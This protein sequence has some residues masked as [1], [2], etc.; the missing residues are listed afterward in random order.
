MSHSYKDLFV[1][2]KSKALAVQIYAVTKQFPR[3][4]RFGLVSQMRRAAV[5]VASSIAEGQGRASK[6]EF[7]QFL[8]TARGSLLE[9]A[10]QLDIAHDLGYLDQLS[11]KKLERT[12]GDVIGL[13]NRLNDSL[14]PQTSCSSTLKRETLKP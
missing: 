11:F 1:W 10:T 3:D 5:S 2:Q 12:T 4:E 8:G 9:L 6:G 14:Q 7:R 13:V